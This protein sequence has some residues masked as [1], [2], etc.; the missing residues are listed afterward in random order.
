MVKMIRRIAISVLLMFLYGNMVAATYTTKNNVNGKFEE[1][2]TWSGGSL[3]GTYDPGVSFTIYDNTTIEIKGKV[4]LNGHLN[5][6]KGSHIT[7]KS[8]STLVIDGD[9]N[10]SDYCYIYLESNSSLF[11]KR[12]LNTYHSSNDYE[13]VEFYMGKKA[14]VVVEENLNSA[15]NGYAL[16]EYDSN[17]DLYV[18]GSISGSAYYRS[19][20]TE[21]AGKENE[22]LANE[23]QLAKTV[24]DMTST[25]QDAKS[26]AYYKNGCTLEIP[27]NTVVEIPQ[28]ET[29]YLSKI[30]MAE[31]STFI[32]NGIVKIV[33]DCTN[34]NSPYVDFDF[35]EYCYQ[36]L[37]NSHPGNTFRNNGSFYCKN[38]N[39]KI[40]T[41]S[42]NT[43]QPVYFTN[44]GSIICSGDF[45][46]EIP[47]TH[48]YNSLCGSSVNASNMN[49][50]S[51]KELTLDGIYNC[52]TMTINLTQGGNVVNFGSNC[53]TNDVSVMNELVLKNNISYLNI[54][55][56]STLNGIDATSVYSGVNVQIEG[57]V[58]VG[59]TS[60]KVT[61]TGD[62]ESQITLC[63]N[64]TVCDHKTDN[65]DTR[66]ESCGDG[67][68]KTSGTVVFRNPMD[69]E[70]E[71]SGHAW[72]SN[73]PE[74][75]YSGNK[76]YISSYDVQNLGGATFIPNKVSYEDCINR[77]FQRGSLLP[78]ELVSFDF[79]KNNYEFVWTTASETNNDYF[80]VEYSKNGKDWVECT[81]H[82]ASMSNTG[83]SYSTE[84]V[85]P[86]NESV[87]SY[88]RLKQVDMDGKY[89]YSNVVAVSFTV[90]NPCSDEFLDQRIKIRELGDKYY[91]VINGELIYCEGDN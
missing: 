4:Y 90:E 73:S 78:I 72:Y 21:H 66:D 1:T 19:N 64:A 74:N 59:N 6:P 45:N 40:I 42:N 82:I 3:P 91:R 23:H 50:Y 63:Y 44:V 32:N 7:L 55:G 9:L 81:D 12:D 49:F 43:G 11:I 62:S 5:F 17:S 35:D 75:E 47:Q 65:L 10:I 16:F 76:N 22:F 31:G 20:S 41:K 56:V 86:I 25:L 80:V 60:N 29:V 77:Q 18:F 2:S 88:F 89:S 37:D 70:T 54:D 71:V 34:E 13:Y 85:I 33:E 15:T 8:G 79:D 14:N 87:F 36:Y 51:H 84:P 83:Y 38:Y 27:S 57:E 24:N 39:Q 46:M 58:Y 67:Y 26:Y 28:N 69:N 61:I 53:S 68:A 48:Y 30:T 52:S